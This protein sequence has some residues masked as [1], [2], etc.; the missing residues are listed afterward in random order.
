VNPTHQSEAHYLFARYSAA[1]AAS[2]IASLPTAP[3]KTFETEFLD[4]KTGTMADVD[5]KRLWSKLLGS[6]ANA[7]GGVV[8][9]GVVARKD[10]STEIDAIV[11]LDLVPDVDAFR[12]RLTELQN[13]AVDPPVRNV[14]IIG[15]RTAPATTQG[16][17]SV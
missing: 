6:F 11:G 1:D 17:V 15:V 12:S 16:F 13:P 10:K 5:L 3:D 8:I 14:E 4:F 2:L 9:W 7:G